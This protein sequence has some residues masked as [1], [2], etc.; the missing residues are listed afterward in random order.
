MPQNQYHEDAQTAKLSAQETLSQRP[1]TTAM[2]SECREASIGARRLTLG[3]L[4][5]NIVSGVLEQLED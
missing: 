1:M 3:L 5:F 4:S 2:H